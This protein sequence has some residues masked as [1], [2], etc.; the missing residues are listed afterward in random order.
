MHQKSI[1][2]FNYPTCVKQGELASDKVS[3]NFMAT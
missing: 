3:S 1:N 2:K